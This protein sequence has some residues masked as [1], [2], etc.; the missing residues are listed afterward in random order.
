MTEQYIRMQKGEGY[1]YEVT[2]GHELRK[3]FF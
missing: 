2:D 1:P 3:R